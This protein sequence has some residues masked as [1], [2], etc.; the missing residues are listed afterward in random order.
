MKKISLW[1]LVQPGFLA[2]IFE[3]NPTAV[4]KIYQKAIRE[5][6]VNPLI[7]LNFIEL[8]LAHPAQ[9]HRLAPTISKSLKRKPA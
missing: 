3:Q 7:Y 9:V 4:C 2:I 5:M 6:P 1:F 8:G